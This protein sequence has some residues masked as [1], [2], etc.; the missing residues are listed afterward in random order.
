M[1]GPTILSSEGPNT[2]KQQGYWVPSSEG[3]QIP[4]HLRKNGEKIG[5]NEEMGYFDM[6]SNAWEW[7]PYWM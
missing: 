6:F 4:E 3:S 1:L 2:S 5:G 7:L